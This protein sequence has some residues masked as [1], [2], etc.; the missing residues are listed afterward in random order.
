MRE[1]E[2]GVFGVG[3]TKALVRI[4]VRNG[5][6]RPRNE[7]S[8]RKGSRERNNYSQKKEK[9]QYKKF[10]K[11]Y[12]YHKKIYNEKNHNNISEIREVIRNH[13]KSDK[14]H[15]VGIQ[16][17]SDDMMSIVKNDILVFVG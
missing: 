14:I 3:V 16:M 13:E 9:R 8:N 17:I 15:L 7:R 5:G 10:L 1:P 12:D 4:S 11:K 6:K 2:G